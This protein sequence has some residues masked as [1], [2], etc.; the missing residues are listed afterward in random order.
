MWVTEKSAS[1]A[2]DQDILPTSAI[3][4]HLGAVV[5]PVDEEQE[6][7]VAP[8][9][10][11]LVPYAAITAMSWGILRIIAQQMSSAVV[12]HSTIRTSFI[13]DNGAELWV[14]PSC[15]SLGA[16]YLSTFHLKL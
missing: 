2:G 7:V 3:R 1:N 9:G 13:P 11:V 16:L 4:H 15:G 10:K 8:Q 12:Q 6:V 14:R 5:D